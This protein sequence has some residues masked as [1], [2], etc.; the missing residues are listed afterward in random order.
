MDTH[1]QG[2]VLAGSVVIG[3]A[4]SVDGCVQQQLGRVTIGRSVRNRD[5]H[6]RRRLP[7]QPTR[8][9]AYSLR[10][11]AVYWQHCCFYAALTA[12]AS[13]VPTTAP[14]QTAAA[15]H[16]DRYPPTEPLPHHD[17]RLTK[18]LG[19]PPFSTYSA[20]VT[21]NLRT[22][23]EVHYTRTHETQTEFAI[24][25]PPL[26]Y[27]READFPSTAHHHFSPYC[28]YYFAIARTPQNNRQFVQQLQS[29]I[30]QHIGT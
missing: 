7:H 26:Y 10:P 11:R 5:R 13:T 24:V 18:T 12:H 25:T 29:L 16:H 23:P 17:R 21:K 3:D 6:A 30:A 14:P 15:V 1:E 4:T 27:A 28:T 2:E 8:L 9:V 22:Q 19:H 20:K